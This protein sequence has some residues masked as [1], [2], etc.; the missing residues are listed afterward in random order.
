[1]PE[2]KNYKTLNIAQ[3]VHITND[4]KNSLKIQRDL[5]KI[6]SENFITISSL[7]AYLRNISTVVKNNTCFRSNPFQYQTII[8]LDFT[9]KWRQR[10]NKS[11]LHFFPTCLI[12]LTNELARFLLCECYCCWCAFAFHSNLNSMSKVKTGDRVPPG[13]KDG[14]RLLGWGRLQQRRH[15][16]R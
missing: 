12:K 10:I 4:L 16:A 6:L 13:V 15:Q 11:F 3:E 9:P 2:S 1:M 14:P 8:S 7:S 5:S